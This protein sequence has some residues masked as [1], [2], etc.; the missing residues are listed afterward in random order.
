MGIL[1]ESSVKQMDVSTR[2]AILK[3]KPGEMT[4]IIA[5]INP[6]N[7]QAV[8]YRIVKLLSKEPAG[9]RDLSDPRVQQVVIEFGRRA[10]RGLQEPVELAVTPT[11]AAFGNVRANGCAAAA[12]LAGEPEPFLG[13]ELG[14]ALVA[15]QGQLVSLFPDLKLPKVFHRSLLAYRLPLIAYCLLLS[16]H[17][18]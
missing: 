13:R 17:D 5:V 7:S 10:H 12:D 16:F 15:I 6:A 4:S 1:P 2:E 11:P 18:G 14:C 8:G 9:Q 3:L